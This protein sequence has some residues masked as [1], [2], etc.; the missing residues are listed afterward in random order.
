MILWAW[1]S[2][3]WSYMIYDI[4]SLIF[5]DMM[6]LWYCEL[7]LSMIWSY[8]IYD[9][10][11]LTDTNDL[12]SLIWSSMIYDS[13]I[14]LAIW[15]MIFFDIWSCLICDIWYSKEDFELIPYIQACVATGS[16]EAD[17]RRHCEWRSKAAS[18]RW[19]AKHNRQLRQ[20]Q[21]QHAK[22]RRHCEWRSTAASPLWVAKHS[23]VATVSGEASLD[24]KKCSKTM[25][26]W[27][28]F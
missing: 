12:L 22:V 20:R 21:A 16:G 15:Y 23:C 6:I 4:V 11:S 24:S 7:D 28:N 2:L 9:I 25:K 13:L 19:V 5:Y 1:S 8:M 27:S 10:I 3:I 18:P 17:E 26:K 14:F